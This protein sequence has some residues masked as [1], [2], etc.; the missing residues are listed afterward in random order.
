[1][2][3]RTEPTALEVIDRWADGVGS[4]AHPD[5]TGRRASHAVRDADGDVWMFDP[6]DA[7]GVDELLAELA[8]GGGAVAGV[9]V[10]SDYHARDGDVLARRYD[11][12]VYVPSSV[13]RA[14]TRIDAPVERVSDGVAGFG[15]REIT[16]LY[17]WN[18][19]LAYR[20]RDRTLYVPDS[21]SSAEKFTVG[22]ERIGMPTVSRLFPPRQRF[23][24]WCP[25]RII[26][27][28]GAGVFADAD[29]VLRE[30]FDG[31][32]RRMPRAVVENVPDE[33]R[34]MVGA[35]D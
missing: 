13:D 5:E 23:D 20:E 31:A 33:L 28:H 7:P 22:D 12:P 3:D 1:M 32:R 8:D 6:I 14:A 30:T 27:G 26:F 25:D 24:G 4:L 21:L 17:A 2:Y 35:L 34:A 16:P 29:A 18:E 9:V 10:C 19:V 15:F 11:V